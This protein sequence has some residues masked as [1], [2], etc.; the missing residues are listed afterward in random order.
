MADINEI[1]KDP[2]VSSEANVF[3]TRAVEQSQKVLLSSG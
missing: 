1:A 2:I 3:A